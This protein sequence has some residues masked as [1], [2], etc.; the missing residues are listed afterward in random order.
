[1]DADV[2]AGEL[3]K[4]IESPSVRER[5]RSFL[6]DTINSLNGIRDIDEEVD[7][8]DSRSPH[9]RK[10][11]DAFVP[12]V[13]LSDLQAQ[14]R[15]RFDDL[16]AKN[17]FANTESDLDED[18]TAVE[19]LEIDRRGRYGY[20]A[21]MAAVVEHDVQTVKNLISLGA[22]RYIEDNAGNTPY[23]KSIKMG[24]GDIAALLQE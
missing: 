21:L 22:D 8:F 7:D 10:T 6:K 17:T 18:E 3:T 14:Q 16:R 2:K 11:D 15:A 9:V 19:V 23:E 12:T 5:V 1:M 24:Y 13:E 20:T 4:H